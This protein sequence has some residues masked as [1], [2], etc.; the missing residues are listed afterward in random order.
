[1]TQQKSSPLQTK[2]CLRT[3]QAGQVSKHLTL[4]LLLRLALLARVTHECT[5][6]QG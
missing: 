3:M 5:R 2:R 6:S 1:M 4:Q